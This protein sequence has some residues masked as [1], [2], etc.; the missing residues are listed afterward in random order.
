MIRVV[1]PA[2]LR[3][4]AG[5]QGEIELEVLPPVTARRVIDTLEEAYPTLRGAIRDIQTK[6]RRP[7]VRFFVCEEDIS[8]QSIDDELPSAVVDG[9]EPFFVI[10]AMAG[11]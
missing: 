1:I 6:R 9:R 11:G 3:T 4:L 8:H 10:G 7:F 5:R 2:H